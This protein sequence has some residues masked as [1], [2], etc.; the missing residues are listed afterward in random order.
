MED[1]FQGVESRTHAW[2]SGRRDLH[3]HALFDVEDVRRLLTDPYREL[4]HRPGL[5][6]VPPEFIHMTILHSGPEADATPEEIKEIISGVRERAAAVEPFDVT[7]ARPSVGHVA[8]ECAGRPGVP[9][10]RLWELT[11]Q[12]TAEVVGDRWPLIPAAFHPHAT[13]AYAGAEAELADRTAM[14]VWLSDHGPDH[15]VTLR[16]KKISLVSQWHDR[17][18]IRWEHLEDIPLG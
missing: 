3:W 4:T 2:V 15:P 18:H 12:A 5:E 6:P 7:F 16:V 13:I 9:A 11:Y 17:R 14:K 8:L 10:R 1:F